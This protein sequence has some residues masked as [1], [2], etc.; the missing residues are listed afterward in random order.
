[1]WGG[2]AQLEE[3]ETNSPMGPIEGLTLRTFNPKTRQW[4]LYWVNSKDGLMTPAQVGG[5]K[6]GIGTFYG[7]DT[8]DG[9][10]IFVR[11]VW[12]AIN[13]DKP[14]FEQSFSDDGGRTWEVNWITDQTRTAAK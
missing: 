9:K 5:F 4:Y 12:S 13:T 8:L 6:D 3:F 7:T 1:M 11:F 14:H 10:P 2:K